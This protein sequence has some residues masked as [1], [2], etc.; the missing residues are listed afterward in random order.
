MRHSAGDMALPLNQFELTMECMPHNFFVLT[1]IRI[2]NIYHF[3]PWAAIGKMVSLNAALES[4]KMLP[5][6]F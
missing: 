1:V 6:R 5:A 3:V 2:L 4:Y